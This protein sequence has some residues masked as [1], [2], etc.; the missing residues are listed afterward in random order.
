[1]INATYLQEFSV[2]EAQTILTPLVIFILGVVVY[3]IFI[4]K[5]YFIKYK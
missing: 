5:F 1:M 2:S 3:A 4:F